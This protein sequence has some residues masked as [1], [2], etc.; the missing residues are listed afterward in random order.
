MMYV[1]IHGTSYIFFQYKPFTAFSIILINPFSPRRKFISI[2]VCYFLHACHTVNNAQ[3]VLKPLL[4]DSAFSQ[5]SG[6]KNRTN[7]SSLQ[8]FIQLFKGSYQIFHEKTAKILC[9]LLKNGKLFSKYFRNCT[10]KERNK[11]QTDSDSRG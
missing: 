3:I 8:V 10:V 7:L 11:I 5:L 9:S 1:C 2:F 4:Q 6:E